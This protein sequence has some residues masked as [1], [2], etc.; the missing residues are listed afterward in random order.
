MS[1]KIFSLENVFAFEIYFCITVTCNERGATVS[2][3]V[4]LEKFRIILE[5]PTIWEAA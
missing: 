4:K 5:F 3:L 1:V 2:I